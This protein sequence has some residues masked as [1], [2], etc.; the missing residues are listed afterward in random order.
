EY[1]VMAEDFTVYVFDRRR[2]LPVL[3]SIEQMAEDTAEAINALGLRDI[4]LFGASQGGMMAMV[5]AIEHPEL[6]R[7]MVLGSTSAHVRQPKQLELI[8]R[9]IDIAKKKDGVGLYLDFGRE[10]YP[11]DVYEQF[12]DLLISAGQ[13]TTEQELSRF[14]IL[15]ESIK[16]FNAADRLDGIQ[17]PVLA[18]GVFE[19]SVL[20]SDATMEIAERLDLRPDFQLFMYTGYGHAAFD[21]A[22]DYR[23]RI[24]SFFTQ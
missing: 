23:D 7:M 19:D 9:W 10:L 12:K 15:A 20:D 18:I 17:C 16:E 22:P 8:D 5:I 24:Y 13:A 14:V 1:A 11:P 6:V 3:Y 21:T 2:E 4:H